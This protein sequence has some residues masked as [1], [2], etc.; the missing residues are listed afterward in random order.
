MSLML[1]CNF[2]TEPS[3]KSQF[4]RYA[5]ITVTKRSDDC[6]VVV[7]GFD[8]VYSLFKS[9]VRIQMV[10]LFSKFFVLLLTSNLW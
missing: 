1:L 6:Q 5:V 4:S 2:S 8:G 9:G 7:L 3:E 10:D